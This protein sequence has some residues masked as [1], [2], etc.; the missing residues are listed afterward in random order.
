MDDDEVLELA[1]EFADLGAELHGDG[2]NRAALQRVV[3]LAVKHVP[4]CAWASVTVVQNGHGTTIASSDDIAR[5]ADRLQYDTG[6]GPCLSAAED[7]CTYAMFDVHDDTRWPTFSSALASRT[8]VRS[9]LSFQLAS[10]ESAALNLFADAAGA[11]DA[12][13]MVTGTIFAAHTSSA[14]AL[15]EA[16]DRAD[17]LQAALES[18]REIGAAIGVLMSYHRVTREVAFELLRSASQ[19]LNRKLRDVA[20]EVVQTGTLPTPRRTSGPSDAH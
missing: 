2:D 18:S 1:A 4:G 16:E 11:F 13:S 3:Q 7:G 15:Y 12:E 5:S 10:K 9:V 8:P 6:E 19:R 20:G 17:N 14:V